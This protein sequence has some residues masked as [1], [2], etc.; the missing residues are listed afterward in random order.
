MATVSA[1]FMKHT[2][3]EIAALIPKYVK[4]VLDSFSNK[5]K[6]NDDKEFVLLFS[7]EAKV[8]IGKRVMGNRNIADYLK[9]LNCEFQADGYTYLYTDDDQLIVTGNC[10]WGNK[11][12]AFTLVMQLDLTEAEP[13]TLITNQMI[14]TK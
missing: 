5:L 2:H 6:E 1:I 7:S 12:S 8:T 14:L 3:A 10:L 11:R 4:L 13:R 9:R